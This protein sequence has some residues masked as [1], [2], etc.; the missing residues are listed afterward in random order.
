MEVTR[1]TI[2]TFNDFEEAKAFGSSRPRAIF[3]SPDPGVYQ[4]IVS[5]T[6]TFK[7]ILRLLYYSWQDIQHQY[8]ALTPKEKTLITE[9]QFEELVTLIAND[10]CP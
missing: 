5:E 4:V 6:E 7:S 8:D 10:M 9:E 3:S 2:Y 1:Q